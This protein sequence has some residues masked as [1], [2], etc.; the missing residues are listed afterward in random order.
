MRGTAR[1]LLAVA[2]TEVKTPR[3]EQNAH[4]SGEFRGEVGRRAEPLLFRSQK[5][6]RLVPA[7]PES[8]NEVRLLTSVAEG[9][10]GN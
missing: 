8:V 10:V 2:W 3:A 4:P 9:E 5:T 1:A 7:D 6:G